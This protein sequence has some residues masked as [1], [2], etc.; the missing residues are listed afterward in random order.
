MIYFD[1]MLTLNHTISK[2]LHDLFDKDATDLDAG[3]VVSVLPQHRVLVRARKQYVGHGF[4][5]LLAFGIEQRGRFT[6][7]FLMYAENLMTGDRSW[8][9]NVLTSS[10]HRVVEQVR[11]QQQ[12]VR[13]HEMWDLG[14]PGVEAMFLN[15]HALTKTPAVVGANPGVGARP[16]V[17]VSYSVRGVPSSFSGGRGVNPPHRAPYF[18]DVKSGAGMTAAGVQKYRRDN[19]GSHLQTAVTEAV[20]RTEERA[21]RRR[22]FCAR[23]RSWH[24][25]RG[26]AARRRWRC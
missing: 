19:P 4:K 26:V 21:R 25:P 20:P 1:R 13:A 9:T 11:A 3:A 7:L 8:Y 10:L 12:V 17:H 22:S 24:G 5:L 16:P 6:P 18:R 23:S 15:P 14:V 2:L